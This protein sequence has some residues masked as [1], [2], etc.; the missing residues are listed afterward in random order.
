MPYKKKD[1]KSLLLYYDYKEQ[2]EVLDDKQLRQ[3]I[4]AMIEYDKNDIEIELDNITKM[5]FIPIKRRLKADKEDW[6]ITC[7]TN[8]KNIQD[9]WDRVKGTY[10]TEYDG[11]RA[12]TMATDKDKEKDKEKDIDT[13]TNNI[14]TYI[15]ENFGITIGGKNYEDI[16]SWL[17]FYPLEVLMYAVDIAVASGKR[18]INYWQGILNNW[19]G[20]NYK[21][22]RDIID[23]EDKSKKEEK[24]YA[25][26]PRMWWP[27]I[28]F[29]Y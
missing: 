26:I 25:G 8:R 20:C 29:N 16:K 27:S 4:Y 21:S 1:K 14:Y 17:S 13:T 19:K 24:Q 7:E 23:N 12:N 22:L 5:A 11:I 6:K 10:T 18:T 2:F 3:L 28:E 15:E 9:Y